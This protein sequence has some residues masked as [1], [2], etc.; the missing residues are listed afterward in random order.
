MLPPT[1]N[2]HTLHA[3][4]AEPEDAASCPGPES[5]PPEETP[6]IATAGSAHRHAAALVTMRFRLAEA[7]GGEGKRVRCGPVGV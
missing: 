3:L 5:D 4:S 7:R 1:D 2:S 6:P